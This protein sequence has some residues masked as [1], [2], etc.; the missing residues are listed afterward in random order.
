M[1]MTWRAMSGRPYFA[2]FHDHEHW[3]GYCLV[4]LRL[5]LAG[6][7]A[8]GGTVQHILPA[9]SY[10]KVT[11]SLRRNASKRKRKRCTSL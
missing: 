5:A 2:G 1:S 10:D 4:L 7:F 8:V 3:P 11:E 6:L 9:T